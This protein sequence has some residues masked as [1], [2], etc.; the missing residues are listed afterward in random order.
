MMI[1]I[2][3]AFIEKKANLAIVCEY[4]TSKIADA[5]PSRQEKAKG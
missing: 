2:S 4:H 1:L 5:L 3:G